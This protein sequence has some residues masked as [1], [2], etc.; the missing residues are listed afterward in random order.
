MIRPTISRMGSET[1]ERLLQVRQRAQEL[2]ARLPAGF[3]T[4][5]TSSVMPE[6]QALLHAVRDLDARFAFDTDG[7]PG[8][9]AAVR[10]ALPSMERDLF[11]AVI[12]DHACEVAALREAMLQ[13]ALVI[14]GGQ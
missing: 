10:H 4:D 6:L 1:N 13:L 7:R 3:E 14:R 8:A 9:I 2:A 5:R 12:E 11:D